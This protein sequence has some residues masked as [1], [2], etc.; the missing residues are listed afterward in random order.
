MLDILF[1]SLALALFVSPILLMVLALTN[2][3]WIAMW[4]AALGSLLI[5]FPA[6]LSFG[7]LT[8]LLFCLQAPAAKAL[9]R[10]HVSRHEWMILL[11]L[12]VLVWIIT[13]PVQVLMAVKL[14]WHY[15]SWLYTAPVVG[16]IGLLLPFLPIN[17]AQSQPS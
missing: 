14:D 11:L 10:G 1:S 3:S 4:L 13:V 15:P 17:K 6:G 9:R 12:G 16:V 2:R 7:P 5:S 8:F